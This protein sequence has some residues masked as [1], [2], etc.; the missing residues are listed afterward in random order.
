MVV[1]FEEMGAMKEGSSMSVC[2]CAVK[3]K[4]GGQRNYRLRREGSF[5]SSETWCCVSMGVRMF[6]LG[7]VFTFLLPDVSWI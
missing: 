4:D 5:D 3:V 7:S 2:L 1:T 6:T